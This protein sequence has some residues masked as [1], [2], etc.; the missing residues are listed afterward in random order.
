MATLQDSRPHNASAMI[1]DIQNNWRQPK[2]LKSQF[3]RWIVTSPPVVESLIAT[4]SGGTQVSRLQRSPGSINT[5]VRKFASHRALTNK[6]Q[7]DTCTSVTSQSDVGRCAGWAHGP[8]DKSGPEWPE[9]SYSRLKQSRSSM[10]Q[11]CRWHRPSS[12]LS[13]VLLCL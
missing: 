7:R 5:L 3:E 6:S 4:L 10:P 1:Q 13:C 8:N 12:A 11:I 2:L 9:Q